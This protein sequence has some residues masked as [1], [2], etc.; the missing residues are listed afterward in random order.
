MAESCCIS[1]GG[2]FWLEVWGADIHAGT[3]GGWDGFWAE[4]SAG[5]RR[6]SAIEVAIEKDAIGKREGLVIA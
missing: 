6:R 3:G 4:V 1:N 2:K 5:V